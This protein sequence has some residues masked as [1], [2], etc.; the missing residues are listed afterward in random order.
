M[1]LVERIRRL[2]ADHSISVRQLEFAAGL[3]EG[4]IGRWNVS[5]PS[6]DKVKKVADYFGVT[7]DYLIDQNDESISTHTARR[8]KISDE[9]LKFAIFNHRG[10]TEITDEMLAEVRQFAQ[11]IA[12]REGNKNGQNR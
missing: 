7:V 12:T 5:I 6:V 11:W 1:T 8:E 4:T 2:C 3:S 9:E 10:D